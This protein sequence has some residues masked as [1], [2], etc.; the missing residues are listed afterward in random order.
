MAT[1]N[2]PELNF[3]KRLYAISSKL[4]QHE[5]KQL[6]Y[7]VSEDLPTH[8]LERVKTSFELFCA[9]ED[10]NKISAENID[11]LKAILDYAQRGHLMNS[12]VPSVQLPS[13]ICN[14]IIR[15]SDMVL[16]GELLVPIS[17]G[18]QSSDFHKLKCF[19][20]KADEPTISYQEM[21]Q[22]STALDMFETLL[23]RNIL[24]SRNLGLLWD[25]LMTI[26]RVDLCQKIEEF[27]LKPPAHSGT[28]E[29]GQSQ[30]AA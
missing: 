25:V 26:G 19:F 6:K 4:T 3:R 7:L 18:L 21:E 22:M 17:N 13:V 30:Q 23:K 24:T 28:Q 14:T 10:A 29:S 15:C 1:P 12:N 8:L 20:I 2:Y 9:L 11:L 27:H 5:L 16:K